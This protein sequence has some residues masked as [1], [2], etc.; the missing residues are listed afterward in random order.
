MKCKYLQ[1]HNAVLEESNLNHPCDQKTEPNEGFFCTNPYAPPPLSDEKNKNVDSLFSLTDPDEIDVAAIRAHRN[2][3]IM[4]NAV[5]VAFLFLI[6]FSYPVI[7]YGIISLRSHI[8][9]YYLYSLPPWVLVLLALLGTVFLLRFFL[10][11]IHCAQNAKMELARMLGLPDNCNN[12]T[13]EQEAHF[14]LREVERIK[15]RKSDNPE[16][17]NLEK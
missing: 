17:D 8:E 15:S 6:G 3:V 2:K 1:D 10:F 11:S 7:L 16:T 4:C 9:Y 13:V 14:I 5:V 12:D